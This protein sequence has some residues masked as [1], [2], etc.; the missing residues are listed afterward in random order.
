MHYRQMA[1]LIGI[2]LGVGAMQAS[3]LTLVKD[4]K[5][6]AAIW[7]TDGGEKAGD[8]QTAEDLASVIQQMSGA[9]LEI[10]SS[11]KDGKPAGGAAAIVVGELAKQMGLQAPPKTPSG[12]GYRLQTKGSHLLLAGESTASTFFAAAHL[13]ETFGCR[14]FFDNAVGTVI[15]AMKTI[16]VGALDIAE[17]PDFISRTIW[18]PNWHGSKWTRMNRVGGMDLS[19]G[20]NWPK[21]FCTTDPKVREEYV[22]NVVARVKGKGAMST[23][24]SPPDGVA[25][26]KCERCT[27]LD[28][29]NYLEP[30]SGTPVM[31]DRYQEFYN[32]VA[33]EVKKANPEALLGHYAYADYT[34]PPKKVKGGLDNLFVSIAPIRFCRVHSL[35]SEICEPRQRCRAMVEGWSEVEKKMVWREYNYNLA[36]ATVPF[37][38]KSIWKDDLPWLKEQ[39]AIGINIE[40]MY[41]PHIY[42][43]HTYLVARMAWDADLDVEAVMDDFYAKFGGPAGPH[44]KAYWD[45]IDEAYRT[46]PV[47]AGSYH[48]VH[49]FWTPELLKTCQADLSAAAKAA[50]GD[51]MLRKRVAMFQLGLDNAKHYIAWRDAI[52]RCDFAAG[53][54]AYDKLIASQDAAYNQKFHP[55]GEYRFGYAPRFLGNGQSAG[56]ARVSDGRQKVLQ[57]PDEWMFRYDAEDAGEA[58]GWFKAPVAEDADGWL[59]VRTYSSPL[60]EQKIPEQL[61]WMWYQTKFRTPKDMPAGPLTLWFMEPDGN[62]IKVWL[63]GKPVTEAA[64]DI[65]SRNPLDLDLGKRLQADAE[66]VLTV[67]LHHRRIS[68]LMLGGLLRPVM[69][70]SGGIPQPVAAAKK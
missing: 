46:T 9:A 47:H 27:A 63:D 52:N 48:G 20:H 26:C 53:Q 59:K 31:S 17:K 65:R 42:G 51:A 66:Y 35:A 49:A 3:A 13:L 24:I 55:V 6:Q 69:I 57:L 60:N 12:D 5:P 36:E 45:R 2:G 23:S 50:G 1:M 56:L 34:L 30:S 37:S 7:Y 39:G 29:P 32:H 21:W 67:K 10:K 33:R 62:A 4:G 38:K 25:Y 22:A 16:E 44:L 11:A 58:A 15:P 40:C 41:M 19:S 68:E 70:Y 61:T 14:W 54:Q 18:G 43:P 64:L 8:R 28:D